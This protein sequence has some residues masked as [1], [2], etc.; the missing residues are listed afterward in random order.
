MWLIGEAWDLWYSDDSW[1][2]MKQARKLRQPRHNAMKTASNRKL[3]LSAK[4]D[5]FKAKVNAL[6]VRSAK[7]LLVDW[8]N[9]EYPGEE[10]FGVWPLSE[11]CNEQWDAWLWQCD[12]DWTDEC[13]ES[14]DEWFSSDLDFQTP[15][16]PSEGCAVDPVYMSDECWDEWD[17]LWEQ[18]N[19]YAEEP[20]YWTDDC[21]M[22][23]LFGEAWSIWHG[24]NEEE[25]AVLKRTV[26]KMTP[27][28][29]AMKATSLKKR[30]A[31]LR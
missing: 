21:D 31:A 16:R 23:D 3:A 13:E 22:V 24:W 19:G 9:P 15:K 20:Y 26:S 6:A 18:C 11:D 30:V 17:N 14:I 5:V 28:N 10:C 4:K 7:T 29:K 8:E 27:R 2:L 1:V 12:D 25:W